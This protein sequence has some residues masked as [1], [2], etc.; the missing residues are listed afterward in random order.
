LNGIQEVDS[1]ILFGSTTSPPAVQVQA[2]F[3]SA[4][5][6]ARYKTQMF[7]TR[8]ARLRRHPPEQKPW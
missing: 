8:I 4:A 2:W 6:Y 7:F 1:S 3:L 5:S